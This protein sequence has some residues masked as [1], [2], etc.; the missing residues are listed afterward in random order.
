MEVQF[1]CI[2]FVIQMKKPYSIRIE[3]K[4]IKQL[5]KIAEKENRTV[6]NLIETAL[7]QY[8]DQSKK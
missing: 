1:I 5:E 2:T 4:I 8:I 7:K 6:A 3:D